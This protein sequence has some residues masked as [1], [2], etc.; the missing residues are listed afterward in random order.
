MKLNAVVK[1]VAYLPFHSKLQNKSIAESLE[2]IT[3]SH[4]KRKH[5]ING[6]TN[7][8]KAR[9]IHAGHFTARLRTMPHSMGMEPL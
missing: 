2:I 7:T 6:I 8:L 4:I 3:A 9:V 5:F 1:I